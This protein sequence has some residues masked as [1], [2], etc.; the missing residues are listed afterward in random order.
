MKYFYRKMKSPLGMLTLVANP[1][2]LVAILWPND[3]MDRVRLPVTTL[4]LTSESNHPVLV[5][6]ESQLKEYFLGGRRTFDLPIEVNGTKFQMKV[7]NRLC[8]I[9]YGKIRTYSDLAVKVGS[10]KACR[11]VGA[12]SGRNPLSIVIPCHR[13]I[14]TSGKLVGFAGG[15]V[16]KKKL[17]ELEGLNVNELI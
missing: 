14:G 6:T 3:R 17:L 16:A 4:D 5:E 13:V 9:P 8:E 11:A 2:N 12:A 7:W 10:P 1:S 15:L